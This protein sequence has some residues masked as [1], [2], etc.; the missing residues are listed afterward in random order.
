M[1]LR[2]P[3]IPLI[4]IDPYTSVWSKS[5]RL[6]ESTVMHWTGSDFTFNGIVTV[7]GK[8]YCFMGTPEGV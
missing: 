1:K 5:D 2:P 6:N 4:T 3:A 8:E 7:D